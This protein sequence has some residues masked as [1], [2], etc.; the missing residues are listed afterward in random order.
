MNGL[1]VLKK[2]K[3]RSPE[4]EVVVMTAYG[5]IE[6]AVNAIKGGAYDYLTKP[7]EKERL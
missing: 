1:E 3:E 5:T 6:T 4:T 2:I 7:V